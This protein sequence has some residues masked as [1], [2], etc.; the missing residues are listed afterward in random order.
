M[1]QMKLGLFLAPGGHHMAA[2]RHPEAYP[3]GVSVKTYLRFAE[4]AER[5]CFDLL[6]VADVF[7]FSPRAKRVDAFRLEPLTLLS[8]L[9]MT[10]SKIGLVATAT[11]S[12]NEP[13]NV[14]R[15][16]ASLDHISGGRAGWNIVTSSAN[17]APNFGVDE[18]SEHAE[19]Y[20]RAD[21]FTQV[22]RG[23]WDCFED[24][25]VI[26]DKENGAFFEP[27]KLRVLNHEGKY[28]KVRGPLS[29]PRCPQG[30]PVLVQAGSSED[31]KNL[32]SKYAEVIFTIQRDL[33]SARAF[34]RDI[35][36]RAISF[37]R[38]PAHALVM[39]GV[40]PIV[41]R[42]RQEA[43]DKYELL[44]SLIH[45][46]AGLLQLSR[47]MGVDL[48]GADVDK[49][50][51]DMD[52]A[53][54][55]QSRSVSIYQQSKRENM[56]VRETYE[57]LVV[58]K[59]HR[60]L[61]GTP[62]DVADSLQEWFENDG[63]DGFNIMPPFTPGGLTDFVDHVVPELQRRNLFRTHYEGSMLRDHLGLPRPAARAG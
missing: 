62:G 46:E 50:L 15:K 39:P 53:K 63:A 48:T 52:V 17:E 2:W 5:G 12:F 32:A 33:E 55:P 47:S 19:R 56:T 34:T 29:L 26:I 6:F 8:A 57:K 37:G 35:K 40:L 31:G 41:G 42:T 49:P 30:N 59:G 21:E 45:T 10:T 25:A 1:R 3:D 20:R 16:F 28:F 43:Q 14:A 22:V 11:T 60:Q 9:S 51:P 18:L 27:S 54:L 4:I 7:S 13:Y 58:S 38:N 24:D 23:L 61:I 36:E 44:Q